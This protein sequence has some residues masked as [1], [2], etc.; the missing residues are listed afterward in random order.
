MI[1]TY[2]LVVKATWRKHIL[3]WDN[4]VSLKITHVA[5]VLRFQQQ[6]VFFLFVCF[7]S[8]KMQRYWLTLEY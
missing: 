3:Y 2:H 5:I 1:G 8:T 6:A 4:T 7:P